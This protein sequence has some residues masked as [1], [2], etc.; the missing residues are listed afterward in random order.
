MS[1]LRI[2]SLLPSATEI[3]HALGLTPQ[4][5]GVSH[6]CDFPPE[7]VDRTV[8]TRAKIEPGLGTREVNAAMEAL[9]TEALSIYEV[10]EDR[11]AAL[12]PTLVL[13]QD[14][15]QVCAVALDDV[16]RAVA[17]RLGPDTRVVSLSPSTLADVF[18]DIARVADAAGVPSRADTVILDARRS[19]DRLAERVADRPRPTVLHLEWIDPP[20]VAG[21]WTP[22]VLRIAGCEPVCAHEGRPTQ[23]SRYEKLASAE[24]DFVFVAPCGFDLDQ[25]ARELDRLGEQHPLRALPAV[26]SGR[27]F[28]FDG[29]ALFNRP[30]PR[31]VDSASA[32]ARAAHGV[33][34]EHAEGFV[35][36]WVPRG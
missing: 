32:A 30:G 6:E 19:L 27:A 28:M 7:M 4:I 31:L 22:E 14:T 8:L 20:M 13:T 2:A 21:H 3:C 23:A 11:L 26:R 5:V 35:R 29:N 1:E 9:A 18:D 10:L 12:S 24:P 33:P 34:F 25:T 17:R 15:C 16:E 36:P